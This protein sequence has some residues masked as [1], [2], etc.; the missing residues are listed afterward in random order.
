[1][2]KMEEKNKVHVCPF[3]RGPSLSIMSIVLNGITSVLQLILG[4]GGFFINKVF[5]CLYIAK[6][7]VKI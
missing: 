5:L 6:V 4:G 7:L 2:K 3:I 1:M